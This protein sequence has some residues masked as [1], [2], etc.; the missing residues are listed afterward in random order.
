MGF[1][2]KIK[3]FAGYIIEHCP[4]KDEI[5]NRDDSAREKV[6]HFQVTFR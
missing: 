2:Q 3:L 6:I 4:V 1:H 5:E